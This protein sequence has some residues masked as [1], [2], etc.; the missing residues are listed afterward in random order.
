MKVLRSGLAIVVFCLALVP[1][2]K[3]ASQVEELGEPVRIS[4]IMYNPPG[5]DAYEFIELQNVGAVAVDLSG[6]SFEGV[7]FRFPEGTPLLAAGASVVLSSDVDP[8]LFSQRYPGITIAGRFG[9]NLANGGE[10]LALKDRNGR[11]I[12]SVDYDDEGAW[13]AAA[14][15]GGHSLEIIDVNGN[16]DDPA[17][18]RASAQTGGSPGA[19][20]PEVP[21]AVVRLNEIMA[22]NVSAVKNGDAYPDWIELHNGGD[23]AVNLAGWS[24]SDDA[25][26]RKYVFPPGVNLLAGGYLV[27]WA[28]DL[29]DA[30]GLHAGFA[31]GRTGETVL[32]FD[33]QTNRVDAI[34]FGLQL[35]D[36]SIGRVD[37]GTGAWELTEPTPGGPNQVAALGLSTNLVINEFLA[38]PA[39]GADDWIEL[40]NKN[41]GLP[42]ALRGT[43]LSTSNA[44]F[45]IRSL[46]FIAP[47][48]FVQLF[49][50]EK[51]GAE[52]V[53]FKLPA[54]G[55]IIV[56]SDQSGLE[57]NR[58]NY[59]TQPEGVT[60]GRLPDGADNLVSFPGSA[61]PGASN[62]LAA[63]S[64][65]L[66]NEVL[67]RNETLADPSGEINDWIEL[68][69]PN[70]TP[71]DLS[72][73]TL[74]VDANQP[75]Q[76][77]FP[78][79]TMIAPQGY[80]LL[81]GDDSRSASTK[82]E[83]PLDLGRSLAD[84]SG[85]VY[86]FNAGGQVV[87]LVEYGFQLP[88]LSIGLSGNTW[89]LL[90]K[91]TPE[92][93]NASAAT[94]GN[95]A[96]VRLNEWL[97]NPTQ[98]DDWFEIYNPDSMPVHL[99]GLYLTD[100]PSPGGQTKFQIPQLSFVPAT[101]WVLY[102]ASGQ[103][104]RGRNHV[105]FTLDVQGEA[106]R[107]YSS[108]LTLDR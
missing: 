55:G 84:E 86:L 83:T 91:P 23:S 16:P 66:V 98:G 88:D 34:S 69:N 61:S 11:T 32:L 75:G 60:M 35:A 85:G 73:M 30:P 41:T 31:L 37:P 1:Q 51:P 12:I 94:L 38:N 57:I 64:G 100:D 92:A 108:S 68:Y 19:A 39:V 42:V 56:L 90:T 71:F 93:A 18:W 105:N 52:H 26:P 3:A 54:A 87:D 106:L 2:T 58:I 78:P 33:S 53:D 20:N 22:E 77:S 104:N 44:L 40:F 49:A 80:L 72:G 14:D 63:Y 107:I 28:D 81:R 103:T 82:F 6:M 17:N 13:P 47:R 8:A 79:G 101:G 48:G 24:L 43:Y 27:V 21:P 97:A 25:D 62:Y 9:G 89:L 102:Q 45:Q 74:S 46:C 4:E 67:A 50:D 15:G 29:T 95:S 10:R 96:D 36:Y 76:W 65:P 7:N 59:G 70:S 99:G 5:G